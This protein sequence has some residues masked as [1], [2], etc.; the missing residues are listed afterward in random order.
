[1]KSSEKKLLLASAF[2]IALVLG[3]GY[4]WQSVNQMPQ[5]VIPN[6][7]MPSPNA[8]DIYSKA[9]FLNAARPSAL[10]EG[11]NSTTGRIE[12]NTLQTWEERLPFY[13]KPELVAWA[14]KNQAAIKT[15]RGGFLYQYRQPPVR[16]FSTVSLHFPKAR[17]MART[18]NAYSHVCAAKGDWRGAA[19]SALDGVELGHDIPRG[20]SLISALVGYAVQAIARRPLEDMASHLDAPICRRSAQRLET[21]HRQRVTFD[22]VLTEDKWTLQA[23]LLEVMPERDWHKGLVSVGATGIAAQ[24]RNKFIPLNKRRL[25]NDVTRYMDQCIETAKQP[26]NRK[27]QPVMPDDPIAQ[28]LISDYSRSR[29]NAVRAETSNVLLMTALALRAYHLE[30]GA[31]PQ[32]LNVLVPSYLQ[33]IPID[34]YGAGEALHYQ[35]QSADY[36]LWSIGTDGKDD[37]GRPVEDKTKKPNTR[38][39]FLVEPESKGDFVFGINN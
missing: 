11:Y 12:S 23:S 6:P 31:Y 7:K 15:L 13:R 29:W 24:L 19:R 26:Y 20:G 17:E 37:G 16:S 10:Y 38:N 28:A 14:A 25:M 5:V 9:Y 34:P 32:K 27:T 22:R 18:L 21:L 1:M 36:K 33:T 2:A 3:A 39:R 30:H 8:F 35:K 4:W